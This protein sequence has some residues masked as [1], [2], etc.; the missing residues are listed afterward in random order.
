MSNET[1][2]AID[3]K[4]DAERKY[5]HKKNCIAEDP[6]DYA[7]HRALGEQDIGDISYKDPWQ[8]ILREETG[9]SLPTN[10]A[11]RCP[12]CGF[13]HM[14]DFPPER[15][16]RCGAYSFLHDPKVLKLKR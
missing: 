11:Y 5:R 6:E 2:K 4:I 10:S 16:F 9:I 12:V 8:F 7:R 14:L 1:Q 13:T 3:K 15:C